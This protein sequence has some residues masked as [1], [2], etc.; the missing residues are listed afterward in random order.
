[1][2]LET[3]QTLQDLEITGTE[4]SQQ[5]D[6]QY[7]VGSDEQ[8][9]Q[10][11]R[12]EDPSAPHQASQAHSSDQPHTSPFYPPLLN[13]FG[14]DS[15]SAIPIDPGLLDARFDHPAAPG[16]GGGGVAGFHQDPWVAQPA[17]SVNIDNFMVSPTS[18]PQYTSSMPLVPGMTSFEPMVS[19]AWSMDGSLTSTST[20]RGP[21]MSSSLSV[22]GTS[23]PASSH[24]PSSPGKGSAGVIGPL[25]ASKGAMPIHLGMQVEPRADDKP[26]K[27]RRQAPGPVAPPET[28]LEKKSHRNNSSPGFSTP[29]VPIAPATTAVAA[30]GDGNQKNNN[31]NSGKSS[32][33]SR[34]KHQQTSTKTTTTTTTTKTSNAPSRPLQAGPSS[35]PPT[36]P[37]RPQQQQQQSSPPP[38]PDPRARNREAANRCRAK[39]KVA[40]AEL[41]ATERAMGAEHQAL[42]QT[43][44]SLRD[45]VLQL[46]NQLLMHGNCDDG[47]IQ[48]YLANSA[49]MV[50][51]GVLGPPA[52]PVTTTTVTTGG[53][54]A[55]I[56]PV[57][58][59][60]VAPG[61]GRS[62]SSSSSRAMLTASPP[63]VPPGVVPPPSAPGA[64]S[65]AG[66]GHRKGDARRY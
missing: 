5:D 28:S 1:M 49:R 22:P 32:G 7:V 50:G 8:P 66:R 43:A 3:L 31:K 62:S 24:S 51:S 9:A 37:A 55:P 27:K 34:S 21:T 35:Q 47:L 52:M 57:P 33:S 60:V 45:E 44:R 40:V 61:A 12:P 46:K 53:G 14:F 56:P 42:T 58:P 59:L 2:P 15:S 39:S 10:P 17:T 36:M 23:T 38:L 26:S 18:L 13:S 65:T 11:F 19:T 20:S 30:A 29:L 41:E 64:G 63:R 54:G 16:P 25:V 48:Q 4:G 6:T